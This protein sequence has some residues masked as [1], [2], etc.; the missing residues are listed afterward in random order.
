MLLAALTCVLLVLTVS[1][2]SMRLPISEILK[3]VFA[4]AEGVTSMILFEIRLPRSV[5]A[6]V[7]GFALGL[8]GCI[9]QTVF[10]NRLATPDVL[11][12]NEGATLSIV[13]FVLFLSAASWPFW[14]APIGSMI[15]VF[16]L[17]KV[18]GIGEVD[19]PILLVSGICLA[20]FLRAIVEFLMS[21]GALHEVQNIYIWMQGSFIGQGYQ[22]S[23]PVLLILIASLPIQ[24]YLTR[25]LD[26]LRLSPAIASSLGANVKL[27]RRI[28]VLTVAVLAALGASIGG[29]I[30][31]VAMASPIIVSSLVKDRTPALWCAGLFG[32]VV[33]LVADTI[34][35]SFAEPQEIAAGVITRVLGGLFLL[36]LLVKDG[37]RKE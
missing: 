14:L 35:R 30:A 20:E 5:A 23:I 12:I 37:A 11:G 33:L 32:A 7:A 24:F 3:A 8:A 31:F 29:P 34:A 28:S 9:S 13:I 27:L 19:G 1:V 21:M 18:C 17:Y 22:T 4:Q 26:I 16:L 15:A 6:L 25:H 10:R 2:G 36:F